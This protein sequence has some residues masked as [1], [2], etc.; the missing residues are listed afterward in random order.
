MKSVFWRSFPLQGGFNYERMQNIG[1]CYAMIPIIK[2]L[3]TTK[4]DQSKA[5]KRHLEI[6]NTT[7]AVSPIILGI[8]AAMEEENTK[9]KNFDENSINA[10]KAS[11]MAP[12]AG[13]GDSL[14]WGTFRVIAAGIG[15]SIAKQGSILGPLL[16]V[17][18][19]NVPNFIVRIGGLKY[20]Y[21]LGIQSLDKF[22]K[23]GMMDKIMSIA[24]IIGLS[25]VGGMIATM[26][27][28]ETPLKWTISGSSIE[29]QKILNEIFPNLLPLLFTFLVYKLIQRKV[30][31]TWITIGIVVFGI[32]AH[33]IGI[34]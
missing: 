18:L 15:V 32:A 13:I 21:Q 2:K 31:I 26:L 19:Y 3:Y 6:F 7:P 9:S 30:S 14:F 24:T 4:E 1:F 5:L 11:L 20:G 10:V 33:V 25:V 17:L 22:Q 16:F 34:L 12:L 28:I 23:N 27:T 29:I 8:T